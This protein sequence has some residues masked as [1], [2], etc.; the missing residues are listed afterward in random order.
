[1]AT[2]E[3]NFAFFLRHTFAETGIVCIYPYSI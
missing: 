2:C 3:R 1:V